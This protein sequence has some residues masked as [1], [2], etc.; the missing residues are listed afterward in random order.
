MTV[1]DTTFNATVPQLNAGQSV[2]ALSDTKIEAD[3]YSLMNV[4]YTENNVP[5]MLSVDISTII[6]FYYAYVCVYAGSS[7]YIDIG[8]STS[9]NRFITNKVVRNP[10]AATVSAK[11]E[12]QRIWLEK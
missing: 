11:I 10:V 7:A 6:G 12:I 5:K 9:K 3:N 2:N 4:L 8:L 1:T